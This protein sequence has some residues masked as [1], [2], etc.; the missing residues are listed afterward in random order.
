MWAWRVVG[1]SGGC[2]SRGMREGRKGGRPEDQVL[3]I[4]S[5]GGNLWCGHRGGWVA[6]MSVGAAWVVGWLWRSLS[7]LAQVSVCDSWSR[8]GM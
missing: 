5:V 8:A 4:Y 2:W 3:C 6:S 1:R 7:W